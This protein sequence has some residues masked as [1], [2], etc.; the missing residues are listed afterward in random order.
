MWKAHRSGRRCACSRWSRHR[1]KGCSPPRITA[2]PPPMSSC[3]RRGARR[4]P[5]AA[6]RRCGA[7]TTRSI[8]RERVP[9]SHRAAARA[10]RALHGHAPQ[11]RP[12]CLRQPVSRLR[13]RVHRLAHRGNGDCYLACATSD[14]VTPVVVPTAIRPGFGRLESITALPQS[15]AAGGSTKPMRR[16]GIKMA[17]GGRADERRT[18]QAIG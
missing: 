17:D 15:A 11:Q 5:A 8:V 1:R 18:D 7:T 2:S 14:P 12:S 10:H 13:G 9:R 16:L 3:A 4:S 6:C